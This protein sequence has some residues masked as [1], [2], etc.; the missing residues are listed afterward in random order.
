VS[1]RW[2]R[3]IADVDRAAWDGLDHGDSP[4]LRHGFLAALEASGTTGGRRGWAPRYVLLEEGGRLRGAVAAFVKHDS[5]G[6]YIFD[7]E[8]AGA[9]ERAGI[10]YY[11]KL[12][13]FAPA[14]PATG[15]RILLAP[16]V[17]R[18]AA[19]AALVA[20]VREVA[21]EARCASIHWLFVAED[22]RARLAELGFA[23]R[24]SF[25][26]HWND[27]GYR[28]FDGWLAALASRK[29]KQV[30]KERAAARA[31][32][33]A[34]DCVHGAD[35]TKDDLADMDRFY[36]STVDE[37]GGQAYLRPGFFAALARE[38]PEPIRFV[39][40]RK[41]GRTIA[42]ALFLE[43]AG[44]LFGRYWGADESIEM[45][46][47]ELAYYVGIERALAGG[48][49]RFEA[50]AQGGHKLLRGFD[51]SPTY[52]CHW[53]RHPGLHA[54]ISEFVGNE[55]RAVAHHMARMAERLP[56]RD[57]SGDPSGEPSGE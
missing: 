37:H 13:I 3:A 49:A 10:P 14:T 19:T 41:D 2:V 5:Y 51:P 39:R 48:L 4:F 23:P 9:S 38:L 24:L 15:R 33:D 28:D 45:L 50:G 53:L 42:G 35:L 8:W 1:V 7:W 56:Y 17:D 27:R 57:P 29:R 11:P 55:A 25:Q 18:D 43:T 12:V 52:S 22:E 44:A 20:G 6:E 16:G 46:H 36:R 40:A 47:F 34:I 32:V 26:F 30:R 54:A 31:A 21:D